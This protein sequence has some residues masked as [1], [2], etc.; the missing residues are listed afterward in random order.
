MADFY[1]TMPSELPKTLPAGTKTRSGCVATSELKFDGQFYRGAWRR[2][3]GTEMGDGGY[4][5]LIDWSSVPIQSPPQEELGECA[6]CGGKA[7][8]NGAGDEFGYGPDYKRDAR[9]C[10]VCWKLSVGETAKAI[11][12]RRAGKELRAGDYVSGRNLANTC[13]IAGKFVRFEGCGIARVELGDGS[14]ERVMDN[15]LRRE[16]EPKRD[17]FHVHVFGI[18][19]QCHGCGK[20][21][22]QLCGERSSAPRKVE[23]FLME[24]VAITIG[25]VPFAGNASISFGPPRPDPYKQHEEMRPT[26]YVF[27]DAQ[28]TGIASG[29]TKREQAKRQLTHGVMRNRDRYGQKLSLVGWPEADDSEP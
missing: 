14:V 15:S 3:D 20:T 25:G 10:A 24:D 21:T 8:R 1:G 27:W 29:L 4:F 7:C 12:A 18:E 17:P 26:S 5:D 23:K 22:L 28:Q 19:E 11:L 16:E 6:A 13:R 9:L 2:L